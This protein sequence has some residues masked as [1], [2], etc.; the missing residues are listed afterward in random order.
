MDMRARRW[1]SRTAVTG[2]ALLAGIAAPATLFAQACPLCYQSAASGSAQFIQA[3]K[4]GI[5]VLI[6]PCVLI[7]TCVS[8]VTYRKRDACDEDEVSIGE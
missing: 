3:L 4:G 2:L 8:V 1:A 6:I 5:V 7:C